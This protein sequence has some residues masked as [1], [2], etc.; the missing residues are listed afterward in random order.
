M[1]AINKVINAKLMS[2]H[3]HMC[4]AKEDLC[5][6]IDILRECPTSQVR[7]T[8]YIFDHIR[9]ISKLHSQL[10]EL[11]NEKKSL[12]MDNLKLMEELR[13]LDDRLSV[14]SDKLDVVM[15]ESYS[16][17][18]KMTALFEKQEKLIKKLGKEKLNET[19]KT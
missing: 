2:A 17:L 7:N 9:D 14:I 13:N 3:S 5:D 18:K 6:V 16:D 4:R 12:T 11:T 15:R 10:I 1:T 8:K 19:Q